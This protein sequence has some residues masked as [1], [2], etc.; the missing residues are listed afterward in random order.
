M[1]LHQSQTVGEHGIGELHG[2]GQGFAEVALNAASVRAWRLVQASL[3]SGRKAT[4]SA[5]VLGGSEVTFMP[6]SE[7]RISY[8]AC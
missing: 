8:R 6:G 2:T 4:C 1:L 5:M 3:S 7:D